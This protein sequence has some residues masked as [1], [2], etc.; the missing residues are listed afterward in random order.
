MSDITELLMV[1]LEWS[2][3]RLAPVYIE[4][5]FTVLLLACECSISREY[6]RAMPQTKTIYY[7]AE[8]LLSDLGLGCIK[9]HPSAKEICLVAD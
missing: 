4:N 5:H 9:T 3:R 1:A 8:M 7:W 2:L 6:E